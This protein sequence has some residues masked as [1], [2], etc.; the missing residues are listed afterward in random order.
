MSPSVDTAVEHIFAKGNGFSVKNMKDVCRKT[1]E[2]C[3]VAFTT[4]E[5]MEE[6]FKVV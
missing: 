3:K 1:P 4:P 2:F 6:L 5:V